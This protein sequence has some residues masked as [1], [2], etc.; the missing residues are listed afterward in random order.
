MPRIVLTCTHSSNKHTDIVVSQEG[1]SPT[2]LISAL[3]LVSADISP[4]D[5]APSWLTTHIV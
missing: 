4:V 5:E 1:A 3:I 2:G